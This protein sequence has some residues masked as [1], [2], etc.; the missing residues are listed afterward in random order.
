M[1]VCV[2]GGE[3]VEVEGVSYVR[4]EMISSSVQHSLPLPVRLHFGM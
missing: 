4:N 3:K 2:C 1:H